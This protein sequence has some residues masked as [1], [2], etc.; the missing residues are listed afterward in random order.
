M[1]FL[2]F[3]RRIVPRS[4]D[5]AKM[6]HGI[7]DRK[8]AGDSVECQ[9]NLAIKYELYKSRKK[10]GVQPGPPEGRP[11]RPFR[12]APPAEPEGAAPRFLGLAQSLWRSGRAAV[13]QASPL[14][15]LGPMDADFWQEMLARRMAVGGRS[16]EKSI[17]LIELYG[18][19]LV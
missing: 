19:Y 3:F 8:T 2:I 9:Y 17:N 10:G 13:S 15:G 5:A 4:F 6:I 7:Y 18:M 1:L 14:H 16:V 11:R 12:P